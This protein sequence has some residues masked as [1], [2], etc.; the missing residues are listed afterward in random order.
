[1]TGGF[2][3][4]RTGN[5]DRSLMPSTCR[6]ATKSDWTCRREEIKKLAERYVYGTKPAKPASVT[7]TV[8][9]TSITVNVSDQGQSASF[10]ASVQLPSGT[11][12]FPG[13]VVVGGVADTATILG[14]GVAVINYN[15][16]L[17]GNEGTPRTSKQGA[18]YSIYGSTSST[19][20]LMPWSWGV[21]RIID[22]IQQSSGAILKANLMGVT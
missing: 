1:M 17:V 11:G 4:F 2:A 5:R 13:V 18:F 19:G 9:N 3:S 12:P 8:S 10:S 22:V 16:L 7:G 14:S 15:P 6:V 21:S 20:L